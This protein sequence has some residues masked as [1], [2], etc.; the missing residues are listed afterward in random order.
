[1]TSSVSVIILTYNEEQHIGRCIRSVK[2]FAKDIFIIDSFSNDKTVEIAKSL[3]ANVLQHKWENNQSKQ[4]NW[5]L[6]N[7]PI[8]T[9]WI[10]RLDA[11]EYVTTKLAKE[12][13]DKIDLLDDDITGI[14]VKRKVY[15]L[16]K[17]IKHG[18]Y[19]PK[20]FLRIWQYGKGYCESLLMDEHIKILE[21]KTINFENDIVDDN[22]NNISWWT[23]KHNNYATREAIQTLNILYNL[24]DYDQITPKF[25]GS[26]DQ[27]KRW[28][29]YR[30]TKMPLFL[31]PFLYFFY[32]YFIKLGFLDGKEGLIFHFL[33]GF[34]YRFLVDAKIYEIEKKAQK[35]N[36][37][38]K[39]VIDESGHDNSKGFWGGTM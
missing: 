21:G 33:Q 34:W 13:I 12:I 31:R 15:F 8:K 25:F 19:Y 22:H 2:P 11:D 30:Y 4:L 7:C 14:Y 24:V 38:I 37:D 28:L 39:Q 9:K 35:E 32:R 20:W 10:M 16:G 23:N 5:G 29:K 1:M 3:G 17:W 6:A 27:R 18:D 36:K 26:Q